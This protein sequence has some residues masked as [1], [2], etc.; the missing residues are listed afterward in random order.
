MAK[1]WHTQKSNQQNNSQSKVGLATASFRST[2]MAGAQVVWTMCR[3][4]IPCKTSK[5]WPQPSPQKFPRRSPEIF[6]VPTPNVHFPLGVSLLLRGEERLAAFQAQTHLGRR[7][8]LNQPDA[9]SMLCWVPWSTRIKHA[10]ESMSGQG[11]RPE[12]SSFC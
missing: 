4:T 7:Q 9:W 1:I 5:A 11:G 8:G 10:E 3:L 12:C 6:P 2:Y